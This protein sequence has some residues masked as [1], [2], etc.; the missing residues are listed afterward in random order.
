MT[1]T[2]LIDVLADEMQNEGVLGVETSR[3]RRKLFE[4]KIDRMIGLTVAF[5][6]SCRNGL[7]PGTTLMR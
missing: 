5:A 4:V 3:S 1:W 6:K 2:A 7:R